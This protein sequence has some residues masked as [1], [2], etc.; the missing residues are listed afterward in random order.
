MRNLSTYQAITC[1]ERGQA[2]LQGPA[3][4]L[5]NHMAGVVSVGLDLGVSDSPVSSLTDEPGREEVVV[6]AQVEF[7]GLAFVMHFIE[8]EKLALGGKRPSVKHSVGQIVGQEG[9]SL[10]N[11]DRM[12][13]VAA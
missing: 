9:S 12:N 2:T 5:P 10:V 7:Q 4:N 13:D 1:A 8:G 3:L 6:E 11:L